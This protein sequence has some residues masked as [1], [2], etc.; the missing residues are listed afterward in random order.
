M[1]DEEK[2]IE[3][4][5]R[6]SSDY[7]EK[8]IQVLEGL[9]AVRKRPGMY[10]GTTAE[11][12][13]HHLVW[14][15]VD[16][17]IDEA[18]AGFCTTVRV[19]INPGDTITVQDDGRGIPV[20][21]VS[22][23]GV[24]AV[25][26]VYTVLH[27]GGKFGEG[28][29]YKVSGGLHGVGASVV[30]ALSEWLEVEVHKEGGIFR[31]R[32]SNGG[33]VEKHLERI[34]D[35]EDTGTIVTFKPDASIFTETTVFS[36]ETIR[37]R[38]RQMAFLNRGVRIVVRDDRG[39]KAIE[40]VFH[41]EGGVKE[42]VAYINKNKTPIMEDIVYCEGIDSGIAAEIAMQYN[43]GY[44]SAIYSFCNNIN[45]HEGG[46]HEEG[47]RLALTRVINTY[48]RANKFLK[49]NDENLTNDDVREGLTAIVSVKHPNPQYEGQTKTKLG[50]S[51]V[52]KIVSNIVG[53]QFTRF[54]AENPKSAKIIMEKVILASNARLAAKNAREATRRKGA[55]D[56]TSL[57]GKLID[58]SSKDAS[59]C[60]IYIVEGNSAGGSAKNGRDAKTQAILP[61]RG[62]ILNVEKAQAKR[63]F[64]NAEI[65]NM[66][67]AIGGGFGNEFNTE[68]IR[69]HKVIIMTDADVDGSH[70]RI[71]LLTFFYRFMRPLIEEGYVYIAQPPL[72]QVTF[73]KKSI[74]AITMTN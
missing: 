42:Y 56:I 24:S 47:F 64:A 7:T 8:N 68:K 60:E 33:H 19:T 3:E 11:A 45:T 17:A 55:L 23:T 26:T 41:Y 25:E 20:G 69:Y 58:C 1:V 43:D 37:D 27:A 22:K 44:T 29:G 73:G 32:F 50:N 18:L 46:T 51:E 72:Y 53:E 40:E 14:E 13:L 6:A 5:E 12:G 15:I 52:R 4:L 74:T 39:E 71:L 63:V 48:A 49:D 61:L 2:E 9:E 54:L 57:P 36:Y 62:K 70:I 28:G 66:I 30:N 34:G 59:E 38:L 67:V 10:I 65:G 21:V 16:N 31:I 35:A